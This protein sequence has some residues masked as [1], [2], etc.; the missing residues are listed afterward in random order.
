MTDRPVIRQ[1]RPVTY[2]GRNE[3][4]ISDDTRYTSTAVVRTIRLAEIEAPA[5][6]ARQLIGILV[7]R[8]DGVTARRAGIV[9]RGRFEYVDCRTG[10]KTIAEF[11]DVPAGVDTFD[12]LRR[13]MSYDE[14]FGVKLFGWNGDIELEPIT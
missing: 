3:A 11:M 14:L 4:R 12:L 6:G 5:E 1:N 7:A 8:V 13:Y 2:A 9:G 10:V